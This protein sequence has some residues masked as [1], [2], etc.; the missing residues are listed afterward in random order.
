[1]RTRL[2]ALVLVAGGA[3]ADAKPASSAVCPIERTIYAQPGN[4]G[5]T[6]GF[7]RP[8]N[9][10]SYA[11]DLV[12]WVRSGGQ[13]FWYGLSSPS[14]YG[15]VYITP[16]VDPALLVP[17]EDGNVPDPRLPAQRPQAG[18]EEGEDFTMMFDAFDANLIAFTAPPQSDSAAPAY[19]FARGLGPLFHYAHGTGI[20][21]LKQHV[22]IDIAF[23]RPVGCSTDPN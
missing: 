9:Q 6:A 7:S 18:A 4:D 3:A 21:D 22:D 8:V 2:L 17:D 5:A 15:G 14:G 10:I 20:Y 12:F 1:M 13:T 19:L 23:W 11:S 16:Q